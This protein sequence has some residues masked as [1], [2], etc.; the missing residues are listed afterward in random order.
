MKKFARVA[1]VCV[2]PEHSIIK[3]KYWRP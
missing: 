3:P 2:K 1:Q